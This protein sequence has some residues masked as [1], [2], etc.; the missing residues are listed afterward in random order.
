MS[1]AEELT[2]KYK[3]LL[4]KYGV[5]TPLRLVHFWAQVDTESKLKSVR[6]SLYY[7]KIE[8]LRGAFKTPFRGKSDAFVRQYLK[9]TVKCANYV[10]SGREGNGSEASGD[11]H[12]FRGGGM[13]QTTFRN[14]YETLEKS[15]GI[16]FTKNP[17]LILEEVNG[18]IA[19]LE[20]WRTTNLNK[21]ADEN[22]L[23]AISDIINIGSKTKTVGDANG[24]KERKEN[25]EKYK[26]IFK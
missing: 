9:N 17:D 19:A 15:T 22:N 11:G 8:G 20:Y 1:K 23:D 21:H 6:E 25:L 5:N 26:Q 7:T 3:T 2:K 18:L 14:G 10:Y 13:L 24:F 4:D 12:K 16:P